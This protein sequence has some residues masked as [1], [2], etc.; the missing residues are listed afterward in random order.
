[1]II[2][3]DEEYVAHLR[4][5]SSSFVLVTF[6]AIRA[7]EA[8]D[9][10]FFAKQPCDKL[11]ITAVG[12][13]A[14]T[15]SWYRAPGIDDALREMQRHTARYDDV[16]A[17]GSSMGGYAAIKYSRVLRANHVLAL[18][19]Q[20]SLDRRERSGPPTQFDAYY[21]DTMRSMGIRTRDVMGH[22]Y[23]VLD[24]N[25]R[26]DVV[27]A[28]WIVSNVHGA[29]V[30]P[31]F[32]TGHVV[33]H[34][35]KGTANLQKLLSSI[36]QPS[37]LRAAISDARRS[38]ALNQSNIIRAAIGRHPLLA[39]RA[40]CC[41]R[42]RRSGAREMVTAD[43]ALVRSLLVSLLAAGRRPAAASLLYLSLYGA[44][45]ERGFVADGTLC[46]TFDGELLTFDPIGNRL[47]ATRDL[48]PRRRHHPVMLWGGSGGAASLAYRRLD[49]G[50][51]AVAATPWSRLQLREAS[52]C[53]HLLSEGHY[54][55]K[56]PNGDIHADRTRADLWERFHPLALV[57]VEPAPAPARQAP[58]LSR[59]A[60]MRIT[61]VSNGVNAIHNNGDHTFIENWTSEDDFDQLRLIYMV[62]SSDENLAIGGAAAAA[63]SRLSN[64]PVDERGHPVALRPVTFNRRGRAA[65]LDVP[66][67]AEG[68][69]SVATSL[70]LP[71]FPW[72][73]GDANAVVP[74][75]Y[76]SDWI[77]V[78]S[79]PRSDG[80]PG[81]LIHVRTAIAPA[82]AMRGVTTSMDGRN[83]PADPYP[84]TG[85][86]YQTCYVTG[87]ATSGASRMP[88]LNSLPPPAQGRSLLYGLQLICRRPGV[89][90]QMVGDSI[91]S[92]YGGMTD[93]TGFAQL[94]AARASGAALAVHFLQSGTYAQPSAGFFQAAARDLDV[95][96][97]AI[98]IIQTWSGNDVH[99]AMTPD[100]AQ[101]AADIA[102]HGAMRHARLV[103]DQGGVPIYLSAVP[104]RTKCIT[105]A[106]DA[107]RLS[108][109]ARC[110]DLAAGGEL[111][112]DLNGLL[113][114][115]GSPAGYRANL[116]EDQLHPN[117]AGHDRVAAA[118]AP[119][120][121]SLIATAEAACAAESRGGSRGE[122]DQNP[123]TA[124][125]T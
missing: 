29:T 57:P 11:D 86:S 66:G 74:Q 59:L 69:A 77:R 64:N 45:S 32:H 106:Q 113:G 85:R 17:Y 5:G 28:D 60:T 73:T 53:S 35:I 58:M 54:L 111:V 116:T 122:G 107:A 80:G 1:M 117:Q 46:F 99:A 91:G 43:L 88:E 27:H 90:L 103:R 95:S 40:L 87:D 2:F 25:D 56:Q 108:S 104:Q 125:G 24:S 65:D 98:A 6:A 81:R 42:A 114:D 71:P 78:R 16:Y 70:D 89:T 22:I 7:Q 63:T 118:L 47:A 92:G 84:L 96:K 112:V 76:F 97:V 50:I 10:T 67:I 123:A 93:H 44:G 19:P 51:E 8:I 109:V 55:S 12:L 102:W 72:L 30:I 21:T 68:S 36:R 101:V 121:A 33:S 100:R 105:A 41:P 62:D 48:R 79:V 3:E 82:S 75:L 31:T 14:K 124:C 20:W 9:G 61:A 23:I 115:G 34:T 119:M 18:A 94:A 38:S 39:F 26:E 49:G 110:A 52:N 37:A 4:E 13:V 15:N 83:N 120:L